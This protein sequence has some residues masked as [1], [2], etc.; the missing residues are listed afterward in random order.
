MWQAL[1][2]TVRTQEISGTLTIKD[3][4]SILWVYNDGELC[5]NQ[6]TV[7]PS[8]NGKL[9]SIVDFGYVADPSTIREAV[10]TID[11]PFCYIYA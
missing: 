7:P 6:N 3:C 2:Q 1:N 4:E 10:S 5:A 11:G 8:A 9:D